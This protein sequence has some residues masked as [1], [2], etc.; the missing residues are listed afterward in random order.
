MNILEPV[1]D[2]VLCVD[3]DFEETTLT[4]GVVVQRTLG[5]VHGATDRWF[6]VFAVGPDVENINPGQWVLVEKSKWTVGIEVEDARFDT[7]NHRKKIWKVDIN[8]CLLI[9]DEKPDNQINV[10]EF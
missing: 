9:S 1:G 5:K 6:K 10:T 4:S 7:D 8:G 2:T 3:A